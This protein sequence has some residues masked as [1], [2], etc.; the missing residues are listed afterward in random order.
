MSE[1]A[2][3]RERR[4]PRWEILINKNYFILFIIFMYFNIQY[5][6]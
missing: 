2:T 6:N 4:R 5:I 3:G 1:R